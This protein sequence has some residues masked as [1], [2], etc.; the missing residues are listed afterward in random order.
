M[1]MGLFY[2][3]NIPQLCYRAALPVGFVY[4]QKGG[5]TKKTC[6]ES[7]QQ[8]TLGAKILN[9][10]RCLFTEGSYVT[11]CAETM[12]HNMTVGDSAQS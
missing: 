9:G 12:S 7:T 1:R 3:Y 4:I 6:F 11:M 10:M 8:T 2:F 5:S